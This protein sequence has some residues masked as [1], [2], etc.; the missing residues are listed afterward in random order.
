MHVTK[1]MKYPSRKALVALGEWAKYS[2]DPT[3]IIIDEQLEK[4]IA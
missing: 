3:Q 2:D 1:M 4:L